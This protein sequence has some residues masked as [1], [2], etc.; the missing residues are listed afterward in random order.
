MKKTLLVFVAVFLITAGAACAPR[1]DN[2]DGILQVVDGKS[3]LLVVETRDGQKKEYT[4]DGS[5]KVSTRLGPLSRT[6]LESGLSVQVETYG[7]IARTVIVTLAE[8]SGTIERVEGG[9]IALRPAGSNQLVK[10]QVK[11]FSVVHSGDA[12]VELGSIPPGGQARALYNP[13]SK[14]AYEIESLTANK[15]VA[16]KQSEALNLP[17]IEGVAASYRLEVLTLAG[18]GGKTFGVR[19]DQDT[20]IYLP[21]KSPGKL[22]DI[23]VAAN[24]LKKST[25][26]EAYFRP[27][28]KTAVIV[29]I[30]KIEP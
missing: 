28:T 20:K 12:K 24:T 25:W 3:G 5:S 29:N 26:I 22:D 17:K 6:D 14:S 2:V 19:I 9:E 11:S 7:R 4:L 30:V 23:I 10:L 27:V 13:V 18:N 8:V 21:D 16:S 1:V 15:P